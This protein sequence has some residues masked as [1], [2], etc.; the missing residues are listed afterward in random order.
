MIIFPNDFSAVKDE[1]EVE[2]I[3]SLNKAELHK[4]ISDSGKDFSMTDVDFGG[5]YYHLALR[6]FTVFRSP[7]P[8]RSAGSGALYIARRVV[9]MGGFLVQFLPP[10]SATSCHYHNL[11]NET[12]HLIAGKATIVADG[13]EVRLKQ[14]ETHEIRPKTIH[15]VR[16]KVQS[17]IILIEIVG[18]PN[19]LSM[20]DHVY[21]S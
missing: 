11:T 7:V 12:Y 5:V 6:G 3:W 2:V 18:N 13:K 15:Q 14:G 20:D 1:K 21:V 4:K 19:G 9:N 16:T 8:A 17:S 10:D